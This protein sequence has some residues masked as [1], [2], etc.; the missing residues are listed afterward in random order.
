MLTYTDRC[1]GIV[2]V[3][4]NGD[5]VHRVP[6]HHVPAGMGPTRLCSALAV[7]LTMGMGYI[8]CHF[9]MC[10][11]GWA[12]PGFVLLSQ[13]Q[14]LEAQKSSSDCADNSHR[15]LFG[16][17]GIFNWENLAEYKRAFEAIFEI[18]D[19][20]VTDGP[21][22]LRL[23]AMLASLA[24]KNRSTGVNFPRHGTLM[25]FNS[26]ATKEFKGGPLISYH[27]SI[28]YNAIDDVQSLSAPLH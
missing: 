3:T 8:A 5:G 16:K 7:S 11:Q 28:C 2:R 4:H 15:R 12:R 9:T 14:C 10:R 13:M 17:S 1:E 22:D 23:F 20:Y 21:P 6:L 25:N 27:Q 26:S 19:Y 18:V 24:Q